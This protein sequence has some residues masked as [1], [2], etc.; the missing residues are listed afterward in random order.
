[1]R[2][3]PNRLAG[4]GSDGRTMDNVRIRFE[5]CSADNMVIL[6]I[7]ANGLTETKRFNSQHQFVF[8]MEPCQL[9][10]GWY[11]V[12]AIAVDRNLLLDTWQRAAELRIV[13][14]DEPARWLSSDSGV[15]VCRG[16][17]D[18]Q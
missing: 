11:Y 13:L 16:H 9:T 15:F 12:N 10:S 18:I 3:T 5:I 7:T 2:T 14:S 1:M 6:N 4:S 8:T 17:W